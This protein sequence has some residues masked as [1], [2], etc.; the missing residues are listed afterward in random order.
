MESHVQNGESRLKSKRQS[1]QCHQKVELAAVG[2]FGF[3]SYFS[4]LLLCDKRPLPPSDSEDWSS[5]PTLPFEEHN[6][7]NGKSQLHI[8]WNS[9]VLCGGRFCL[10][11]KIKTLT[12]AKSRIVGCLLTGENNI[13]SEKSKAFISTP[14]SHHNDSPNFS[15]LKPHTAPVNHKSNQSSQSNQIRSNNGIR[16]LLQANWLSWTSWRAFSCSGSPSK[17]AAY[18]LLNNYFWYLLL[19]G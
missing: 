2:A 16:G 8:Q 3:S 15:C 19:I 1:L 9:R 5:Q 10:L 11:D 4:S 18:G 14:K 7:A 13:L 12:S 6:V 17:L